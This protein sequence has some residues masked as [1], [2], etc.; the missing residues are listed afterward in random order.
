MV[1]KKEKWQCDK[2][3]KLNMKLRPIH[4]TKEITR[5]ACPRCVLQMFETFYANV[6]GNLSKSSEAIVEKFLKKEFRIYEKNSWR[7]RITRR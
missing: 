4:I 7:S 1:N 3:D 6:Y 5:Y 2:C